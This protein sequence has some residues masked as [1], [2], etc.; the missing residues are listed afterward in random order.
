MGKQVFGGVV[1][2][3]DEIPRILKDWDQS[4]NSTYDDSA[5]VNAFSHQRRTRY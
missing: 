3:R 4:C 2:A 5:S 1:D